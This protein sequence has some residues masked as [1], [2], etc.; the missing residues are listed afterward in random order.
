MK[1]EREQ[2]SLELWFA[3]PRNKR[4]WRLHQFL[5]K[6]KAPPH[7]EMVINIFEHRRRGTTRG[8]EQDKNALEILLHVG[9][10]TAM[11]T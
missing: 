5:P 10:K 1:N 11:R 4:E 3:A 2:S 8:R 6:N 9:D 7:K